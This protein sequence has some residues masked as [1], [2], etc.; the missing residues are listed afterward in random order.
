M[1][2][3]YK[4]TLHF[5]LALNWRSISKDVAT[6][7]VISKCKDYKRNHWRKMERITEKGSNRPALPT[8][9]NNKRNKKLQLNA[10]VNAQ[11]HACI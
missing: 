4:P 3:S 1:W 2:N 6:C 9:C 10:Q 8:L 11:G 5:Q 7:D